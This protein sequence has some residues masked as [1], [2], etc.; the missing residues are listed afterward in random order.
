MNGAASHNSSLG[1]VIAF[2]TT[3]SEIYLFSPAESKVLRILG[4]VHTHGIKDFKF[5]DYGLHGEGW[6]VGGDGKLVQW[7][8][9]KG[10]SI[11]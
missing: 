7:D 1:T 10:K 8:L 2:G 9:N 4:D 5:K 3:D 11:R 6:S